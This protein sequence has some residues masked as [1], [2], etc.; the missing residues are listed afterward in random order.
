M[1]LG[2]NVRWPPECP[3]DL[4]DD[5]INETHSALQMYDSVKEG[6]QVTISFDF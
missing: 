4:L 3:D 5:A 2:A 6:R 1:Y